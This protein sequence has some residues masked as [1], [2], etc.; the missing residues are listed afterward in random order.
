MGLI[1]LLTKANQVTVVNTG[2]GT[3]SRPLNDLVVATT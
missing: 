1:Q 2:A 3:L